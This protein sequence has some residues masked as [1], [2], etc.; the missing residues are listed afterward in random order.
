VLYV[1]CDYPADVGAASLVYVAIA[2][3]VTALSS[4]WRRAMNIHVFHQPRA[5]AG[6]F[7]LGVSET[8][9]KADTANLTAVRQKKRASAEGTQDQPDLDGIDFDPK[10]TPAGRWA[11]RNL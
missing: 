8:A 7:N 6:G 1:S 11:R 4:W 9:Q 2:I 10:L 5:I 3:C